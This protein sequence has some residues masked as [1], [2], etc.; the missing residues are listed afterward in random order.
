MRQLGLK[1]KLSDNYIVLVVAASL[2]IMTII[3]PNYLSASNLA[4]ILSSSAIY[5][6]VAAAMTISI[7][8]GEFD[9]SVS[10]LLGLITILFADWSQRLGV[11]PAVLLCLVTGTLAGLLN[12][13]LVGVLRISSFVATLGTMQIFKGIALTYC[14]S[15]PVSCYNETLFAFTTGKFLGI[16]NLAYFFVLSLALAQLVL[17]FTRFG[18]NVFAVGGNYNA[19]RMAGINVTVIKIWLFVILG[20]ATAA[21]GIF[22]AAK[23]NSGNALYGSDL[24]MT[25]V[26][27]VVIGGS[28]LSGGKGSAFKTFWGMIFM[29]VLFN[30]LLKLKVQGSWQNFLTGIILIV[31]IMIDA[32]VSYRRK[33]LEH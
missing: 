30:A 25:V 9:L 4:G 21:A 23:T 31:V 15:S 12:G 6:V 29:G 19:A 1:K 22:M 28:S 7:I 2:L 16:P 11:G 14:G 18:R 13:I 17:A 20:F 8:G 3:K 10:T 27:G 32:V 24:T 33:K 5:G 26:T